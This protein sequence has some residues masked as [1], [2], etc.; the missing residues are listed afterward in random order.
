MSDEDPGFI[1]KSI[2]P[3]FR[4]PD[5]DGSKDRPEPDK[6]FQERDNI[7][8]DFHLFDGHWIRVSNK[9]EWYESPNVPKI[10]AEHKYI[11]RNID[12]GRPYEKFYMENLDS[13]EFASDM[14]NSGDLPSGKGKFR[15]EPSIETKYP[16]SGDNDF[17]LVEYNV[18]ARLKYSMPGGVSILPRFLAYPLNRFYKWAFLKF[19][20]EEMI[21]HDGEFARQKLIEYFEYIRKYHGEEPVQSK[22]REASF[23]PAVEEGVFFQ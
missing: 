21:E 8:S 19:L 7:W 18:D 13:G 14:E 2:M 5:P 4:T 20:G 17:C 11:F 22:T 1:E 23:K 6:E 15:I 3:W 16:P 12:M 10:Y 9:V